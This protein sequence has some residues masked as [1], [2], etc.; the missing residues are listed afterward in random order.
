MTEST[1]ILHRGSRK[2]ERSEVESCE[3][4]EGTSTWFPTPHKTVLE[5]VEGSLTNAGFSIRKSQFALSADNAQ[6]F[7]TLDLASPIVEGVSLAVGV[8]N[9]VDKVF[10]IGMTAGSRVFVCDNLS[11]NSEIYV[12]KRHTRFGMNRFDEGIS[13]SI[14]ALA[15]FQQVEAKRIEH[16]QACEL[17]EQ[18]AASCLLHAYEQGILSSTLLPQAIAEWRKPS[19]SAFEPRT[20]WS[21]FNAGT[22]AMK[23]RESNPTKFTLLTMKLYGLIDAETKYSAI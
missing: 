14:V 21:L 1:L 19:F 4:V 9:S 12:S 18:Q 7:A 13:K 5:T 8:R 15:Q 6:F 16:Y 23:A 20:A 2:V 17:T 11:F 10:P 3:H 22:F